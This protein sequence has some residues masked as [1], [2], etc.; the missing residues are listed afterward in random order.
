[1][2]FLHFRFGDRYHDYLH[3]DSAEQ[4]SLVENAPEETCVL[5]L[6]TRDF[7]IE[8]REGRRAALCHILALA[9]WHHIMSVRS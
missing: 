9:K 3:A 6:R 2:R 4:R 8:Q 7:N 1:M 5:M